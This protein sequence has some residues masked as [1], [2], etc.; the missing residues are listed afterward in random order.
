MKKTIKQFAILSLLILAATT[1]PN[2]A[3]AAD[4]IPPA[5]P[6]AP[7]GEATKGETSLREI[8][9]T[10]INFFL[11]FLG[12]VAVI[13]VIYAGVT[14]VTSAGEDEKMQSAKKTIMYAAIGLIIVLISYAIVGMII[15]AGTGAEV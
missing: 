7:I 2:L 11:T 4:I 8:V 1:L 5:N 6:F 14:Y 13:M 15:A 10:M 12:I 9:L 3:L